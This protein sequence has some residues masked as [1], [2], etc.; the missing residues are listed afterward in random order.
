[1]PTKFHVSAWSYE[2]LHEAILVHL[3]PTVTQPFSALQLVTE[4][5]SDIL[6][7]HIF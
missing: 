5:E 2:I 6:H 4:Y 3:R 7:L 1:M